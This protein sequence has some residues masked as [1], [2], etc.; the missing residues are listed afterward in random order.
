MEVIMFR[1][2]GGGGR[3]QV[4]HHAVPQ[5][6]ERTQAVHPPAKSPPQAKSPRPAPAIGPRTPAFK[7]PHAPQLPGGSSAN[8]LARTTTHIPPSQPFVPKRFAS[9]IGTHALESINKGS[10]A[11]TTGLCRD[12]FDS[13]SREQALDRST[14][15]NKYFREPLKGKIIPNRIEFRQFLVTK[16]FSEFGNHLSPKLQKL[17]KEQLNDLGDKDAYELFLQFSDISKAYLEVEDEKVQLENEVSALEKSRKAKGGKITDKENEKIDRILDLEEEIQ[18]L[19]QRMASLELDCFIRTSLAHHKK[20]DALQPKEL[21]KKEK[22]MVATSG[23]TKPQM[24]NL[25]NL[26]HAYAIKVNEL[27]QLDRN[28]QPDEY[29]KKEKECVNCM[30]ALIAVSGLHPKDLGK[31]ALK[32]EQEHRTTAEQK[33][34]PDFFMS[35]ESKY[36]TGAGASCASYLLTALLMLVVSWVILDKLENERKG[37]EEKRSIFA[38]EALGKNHQTTIDLE[39]MKY[40]LQYHPGLQDELHE[41][42]QEIE[43]LN[44]QLITAVNEYQK[45]SREQLNLKNITSDMAKEKIN[46][47][48]ALEAYLKKSHEPVQKK[49]IEINLLIK[50]INEKMH[51]LRGNYKEQHMRIKAGNILDGCRVEFDTIN[52]MGSLLSPKKK[53][54]IEHYR[55]EYQKF[56]KTDI[57]T[58]DK[59]KYIKDLQ[60]FKSSLHAFRMNISAKAVPID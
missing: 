18:K 3:P 40:D 16:V 6:M 32:F 26:Q 60:T 46:D 9:G 49:E 37:E 36:L 41:D 11:L 39:S 25:T 1:V 48:A 55:N 2:P 33:I 17:F 42:I 5:R 47:Y 52:H 34:N 44:S 43:E 4:P 59:E 13:Y 50:T 58:V 31:L 56:Q 24:E 38:H 12:L 7:A 8:Y 53:A 15:Y 29:Q 57:E 23:L 10:T 21:E 54:Q 45:A 19:D 14:L 28:L 27:N 22:K 30:N 35:T 20:M 51:T